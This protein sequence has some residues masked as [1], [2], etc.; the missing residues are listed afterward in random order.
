MFT[1]LKLLLVGLVGLVALGVVL[2]AVSLVIG[3]TFG[4]AT[5]LLFKV[6]PVVLIGYV[7]LRFIAP[8]RKQLSA[9]DQ[10]WLES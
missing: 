2:S 8:K 4:I 10:K 9:A 3:V 7:I 6:A 5:F 1:L